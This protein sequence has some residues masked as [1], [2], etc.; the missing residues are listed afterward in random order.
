MSDFFFY[1]CAIEEVMEKISLHNYVFLIFD[2][3][4]V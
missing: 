4:I 2:Y 3:S 1:K